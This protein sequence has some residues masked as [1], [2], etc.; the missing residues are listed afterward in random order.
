MRPCRQNYRFHRSFD[1]AHRVDDQTQWF[2]TVGQQLVVHNYR[3][4]VL[5]N[6]VYRSNISV[7][8]W[9][10]PP[11]LVDGTWNAHGWRLM[12]DGFRRVQVSHR[13]LHQGHVRARRRERL[14][15]LLGRMDRR[16]SNCLVKELGNYLINVELLATNDKKHKQTTLTQIHEVN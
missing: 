5:I 4:I 16:Y 6:F 2:A 9:Y 15:R 12:V 11:P 14:W 3:T 10:R 1:F 7:W 13:S 8:L